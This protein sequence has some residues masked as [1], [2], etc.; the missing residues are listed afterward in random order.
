[1]VHTPGQPDD[2]HQPRP[3]IVVSEDVRN[4]LTDDLIVVPLYS[5]GKVGP[6]RVP[7]ARGTGGFPRASVAYCEE[8]TTVD[9]DFLARGPLGRRLSPAQL[10]DVIRGIRRALGD[11]LP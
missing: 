11:V 4:R 7:L 10:A 3:G 2:R 9:R 8:V 5:A 6:T 1:M